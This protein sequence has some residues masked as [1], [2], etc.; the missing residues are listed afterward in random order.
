[1]IETNHRFEAYQSEVQAITLA[2]ISFDQ[3][4]QLTGSE[5]KPEGA[6]LMYIIPSQPV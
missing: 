3:W 2:E 6:E 5:A 4:L 1:M